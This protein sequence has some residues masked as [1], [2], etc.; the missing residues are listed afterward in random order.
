MLSLNIPLP[1]IMTFFFVFL[2]VAAILF[3]LP[4]FDNR[5]IPILFKAGL[6]FSVA[7]ILFPVLNLAPIP[8]VERI[9]PFFAAVFNEI[10]VGV[11][12][13]L[14]VRVV[15]AG[16]QL[17][18]QLSGYQMGFAVAN[19]MDPM[20]SSQVSII[21]QL[22]FMTA[23]LL[24]L[25]FNAHHFMLK[26]LAESFRL[27]PPFGL[28]VSKEFATELV[29]LGAAMFVL[30][31]KIAAPVMGALLLTSVALGLIARTV[32]QMNIFIVAFPLKIVTG[33]LFLAYAMPYLASFLQGVFG[34]MGDRILLLFRMG[35][36]G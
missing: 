10:A 16:I 5:S 17:A 28:S 18:G 4:V 21:G 13:G 32:P 3:S 15:F 14:S 26:A 29:G 9:V 6:A 12:I 20:T 24:F 27:V 25:A 33:L 30:A 2:R 31:I 19:V 23:L 35:A 8:D 36:S 22:K 34:E 11:A 1:Q 7:M